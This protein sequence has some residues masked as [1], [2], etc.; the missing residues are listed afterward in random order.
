MRSGE[1]PRA[2]GEQ[3]SN[4]IYVVDSDGELA[5]INTHTL[6]VREIGN[7]GVQLTDISFAPD[8]KLYGISFSEL[9][10]INPNTGHATAIGALGGGDDGMNAL[11]IDAAGKAYAYSD[12]TDKLFKVNLQTGH[13]S[14]VGGQSSHESAGDLAFD[15]GKLLLADTQ[16]QLLTLNPSNGAVTHEVADHTANLFGLIATDAHHLYGFAGTT[17][18]SLNANAGT[19]TLDEHLASSGLTQIFGA[20]FDGYFTHG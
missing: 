18:Y 6:A 15:L 17:M 19:K 14:A 13:A 3:M 7:T 20:A 12:A 11:A 8:H 4:K 2:W 9:Y 16:D 10:Q 1:R 5:T